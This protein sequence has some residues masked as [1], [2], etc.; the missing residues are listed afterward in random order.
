MGHLSH[1]LSSQASGI[2][3]EEELERTQESEAMDVWVR[4]EYLL[5]TAWQL[6]T[7]PHSSCDSR[8]E[9]HTRSNQAKSQHG[10]EGWA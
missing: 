5:D 4:K 3:L 7:G 1:I 2:I 6:H 8:H 10:V 9:P